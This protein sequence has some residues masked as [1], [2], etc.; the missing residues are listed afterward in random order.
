MTV[1]AGAITGDLELCTV[2]LPEGVGAR[3]RYAGTGEWY[4]VK[5]SPAPPAAFPE[6]DHPAVHRRVLQILT[7]P[8]PV[9]HGNEM[10]VQLQSRSRDA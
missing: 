4:A 9:E 5:G 10:P 3:V 7:T 1:E 2:L 8:G 6:A